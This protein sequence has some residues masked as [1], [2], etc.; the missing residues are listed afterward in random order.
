ME[1]ALLER[2]QAAARE[3]QCRR[4]LSRLREMLQEA[5]AEGEKRIADAVEEVCGLCYHL[6]FSPLHNFKSTLTGIGSQT[7]QRMQAQLEQRETEIHR[8]STKVLYDLPLPEKVPP[9]PTP[10]SPSPL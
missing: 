2:D 5:E 7:R 6:C 8:L 3:T 4:E 9:G 10:F 1:E